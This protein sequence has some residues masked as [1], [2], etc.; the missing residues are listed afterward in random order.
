MLYKTRFLRS[1]YSDHLSPL[2][3]QDSLFTKAKTLRYAQEEGEHNL[4]IIIK[5]PIEDKIIVTKIYYMKAL[6]FL[7]ECNLRIFPST[8]TILHLNNKIRNTGSHR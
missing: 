8:I 7:F 4:I 5:F 6:F 3:P 2:K 1:E